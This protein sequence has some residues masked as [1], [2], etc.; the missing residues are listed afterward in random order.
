MN[1]WLIGKLN[2]HLDY[3]LLFLSKNSLKISHFNDGQ[4]DLVSDFAP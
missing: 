1:L 4:F 3:I 2:H